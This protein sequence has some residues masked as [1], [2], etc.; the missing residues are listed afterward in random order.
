MKICT[1]FGHK[2]TPAEVE[3]P[4][5]KLLTDLIEREEVEL[6]LVGKEG[7]FDRLVLK[8][9]KELEKTFPHIRFAVVF[10][11]LPDKGKRHD[12]VNTIY[13][14]ELRTVPKGYSVSY[15]NR[16][17]TERSDYVVSYVNRGFGS[18]AKFVDIAEKQG[19]TVLNLAK[20]KK[21]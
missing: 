9:L 6:F 2:N 12:G 21:A 10:A 16:W 7:N 19:V 5:K 20:Q 1:F 11:T 13:P 4:L 3:I 15:R 17:M 8:V 18:A 14:E